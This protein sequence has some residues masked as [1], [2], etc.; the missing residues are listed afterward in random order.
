M[1]FIVQLV[2]QEPMEELAAPEPIDVGVDASRDEDITVTGTFRPP[3]AARYTRYKD[4]TEIPYAPED[5][6][7]EGIKMIKTLQESLS[8]LAIGNKLREQVWERELKTLVKEVPPTTLIAVCG[9]TGAGKSS[10][11]NAVLEVPTSGMRACTSTITRIS[12]HN[13]PK[14]ITAKVSFLTRREWEEELTILLRE[15]VDETDG[16]GNLSDPNSEAGI[17][18]QKVNALYPDLELEQLLTLDV[19]EIID[20]D[21]EVSETLDTTEDIKASTS[22]RFEKKIAKYIN[23]EEEVEEEQFSSSRTKYALWPLVRQVDICCNARALSTGAIIVDLPGVADSNAARNKI[24]RAYMAEADCYW[25]VAPIQRAVDDKTA[26]ALEK[27]IT[28]AE[29]LQKDLD[30]H[31]KGFTD[32]R[33]YESAFTEEHLTDKKRKNYRSGKQETP[34]RCRLGANANDNGSETATSFSD[35][36]YDSGDDSD[37]DPKASDSTPPESDAM[38]VIPEETEASLQEKLEKNEQFID[39]LRKELEAAKSQKGELSEQRWILEQ[40]RAMVQKEKNAFCSQKRSE[41]ACRAL[42]EDFRSGL[43]MLD[44]VAAENEDPEGLNPFHP[45]TDYSTIDLPVFPCATRDYLRLKGMLYCL[46]LQDRF[47]MIT[48][49]GQVTGDGEASCFTK[50]EDTGI[51]ELQQWCHSLTSI[52]RERASKRFLFRLYMFAQQI[53]TY[54]QHI[55]N[56][57]AANRTALRKKWETPQPALTVARFDDSR[58]K[59]EMNRP[60]FTLRRMGSW[61]YSGRTIDLNVDLVQPFTESISN[62]WST[63]FQTD[64]LNRFETGAIDAIGR[65]LND[66]EKSVS[67]ELK[68]LVK[69]QRQLSLEDAKLNISSATDAVNLTIT[70]QQRRISRS[71]APRIQELMEDTYLKAVKEPSGRG[72]YRRRQDRICE[73]LEIE[74]NRNE[75]FEGGAK[76]IMDRLDEVAVAVGNALYESV[77]TVLAQKI[78]VNLSV[79]WEVVLDD[80]AQVRARKNMAEVAAGVSDQLSFWLEAARHEYA[81]PEQ[82]DELRDEDFDFDEELRDEEFDV[83]SESEFDIDDESRDEEFDVDSYSDSS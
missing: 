44:D 42:K 3:A 25:I 6:I 54:T 80:P 66:F 60:L 20:L 78:E 40:Q 79:L 22:K 39:S 74:E 11:I 2:K 56:T 77:G 10:V 41:S 47:V 18:W 33:P 69:L 53:Q 64:M 23:S 15:L 68:D 1:G 36:D 48:L 72:S 17:A 63:L 59:P 58:E 19:Q 27:Q 7:Q 26:R 31:L 30:G 62:A 28:R 83:G 34:K 73:F 37:G 21:P 12:Y 82:D 51:P 52:A 81:L 45:R 4:A 43:K 14:S 67:E 61:Q 5:A 70:K 75:M 46:A 16:G 50:V 35:S 71:M 24:A 38:A 9:A 32:G 13:D 57:T 8:K 55:G 49:I 65:L 76:V 29:V